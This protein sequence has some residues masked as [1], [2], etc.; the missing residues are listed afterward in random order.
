MA[1]QDLFHQQEEA[2]G[3]V[4]WHAELERLRGEILAKEK[5]DPVAA[6]ASFNEAL[7]TARKQK[8]K[9]LELRAATSYGRLLRD[10]GRAKQARAQLAPVYEWF[11][12]GHTLPDLVDAKALLEE[13][14]E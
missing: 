13:L 11:T 6:E 8:A 1:R 12:E 5:N 14:G 4:F 7:G 9:G 10:Q 3:Q 2:A